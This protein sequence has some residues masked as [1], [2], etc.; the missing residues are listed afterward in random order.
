MT[1]S[2]ACLVLRKVHAAPP[3]TAELLPVFSHFIN[4]LNNFLFLF[5]PMGAALLQV[6]QALEISRHTMMVRLSMVLSGQDPQPLSP[7]WPG[8][9]D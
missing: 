5:P 7:V 4:P 2:S 9:K 3:P 1:C 6:L 8:L